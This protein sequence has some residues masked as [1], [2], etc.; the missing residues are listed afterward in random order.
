MALGDAISV[1]PWLVRVSRNGKRGYDPIWKERLI[2]AALEPGVSIAKLALEHGVN[3]N[4][5]RNW[6]KLHR[7]RQGE[8]G[9]RVLP[10]PT[11]S[12][13]V[14]VVEVAQTTARKPATPLVQASLA[15][16]RL[17]ASLPN[18]VQLEL[19]NA[20]VQALSAF[21]E[22]LGRCDVPAR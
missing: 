16:L 2:A 7:Q 15:G 17:K 1:P 3:A 12:A 8:R 6:V 14:P 4:Q 11:S 10:P 22:V 5:L 20:D 19:A 13:F 9:P 21:I 18:G